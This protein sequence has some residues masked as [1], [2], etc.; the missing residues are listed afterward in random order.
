MRHG[1]SSAEGISARHCRKP[2]VWE[3]A[4]LQEFWQGGEWTRAAF[5]FRFVGRGGKGSWEGELAEG[6]ESKSLSQLFG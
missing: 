2:G 5:P 6:K 1:Q 4:E 3:A